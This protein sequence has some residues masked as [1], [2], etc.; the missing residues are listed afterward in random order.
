M[1][2]PLDNYN[3]AVSPIFN[4]IKDQAEEAVFLHYDIAKETLQLFRSEES[5]KNGDRYI[6]AIQYEGSNDY[7]KREPHVV[8]I[9]FKRANLPSELK[10]KL[11]DIK[12]FRRDKNTGPAIN[13]QSES[14]AFKFE[15]L[16]TEARETINNIIRVLK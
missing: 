10:Q 6:R 5:Y 13:P 4:F 1:K 3:F 9:R 16:S 2:T 8:S 15:R 7:V 12:E 11:E 14:I